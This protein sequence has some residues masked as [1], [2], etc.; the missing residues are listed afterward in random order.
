MFVCACVCVCVVALYTCDFIFFSFSIFTSFFLH[1]RLQPNRF[2]FFFSSVLFFCGGA[3]DG[4]IWQ[5][6]QGEEAN[7]DLMR[8]RA[9]GIER[10]IATVM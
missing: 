6:A 10:C 7:A 1:V 2:F 9:G 8:R 4:A 3:S 5:R